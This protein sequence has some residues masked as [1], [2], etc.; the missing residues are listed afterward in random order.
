[1][2]ATEWI[3]DIILILVVFRQL[4]EGRLDVKSFLIPLGIVAFVAY[5]YLD[6]VPTGGNDLVLI[7]TLMS[8][9]AALGVAA[10]CLHQDPY[11]RMSTS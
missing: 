1:M 4:R 2:T 10:W 6:T 5:M 3:T 11:G 7:G 8:V 9:G